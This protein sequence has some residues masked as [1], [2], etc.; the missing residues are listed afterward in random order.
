L[1]AVERQHL[2]GLLATAA[3]PE[4]RTAATGK[5]HWIE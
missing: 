1:F 3:R 2:L 5:N 4:A